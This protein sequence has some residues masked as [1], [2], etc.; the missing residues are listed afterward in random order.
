AS[1]AFDHLF[2]VGLESGTFPSRAPRS[3]VL[4]EWERERLVAAGLSID[5]P[6]AWDT[7]ERE[8]FR[9]LVAGAR[10]GL[11]LAWSQVDGAGRE[12]VRSAFVDEV[13]EAAA[14]DCEEIPL[15]RV[16]T[17]GMPLCAT[18][19]AA[20]HAHRVATIEQGRASGALSPWNGEIRDPS[21]RRWIAHEFGED[22][23][24]SPTQLEHYA[25]CAWAYFAERLLRIETREEPD[26]GIEPSVRGRI[27][28]RALERFYDF[29]SRERGGAPVLLREDEG[30]KAVRDLERELDA[31]I[32]E[33]ERDGTW[34]GA[35][36]LRTA[37]RD[38]LARIL[39]R[40]VEFELDWNRKLFGNRGNNPR[41]LRTGVESH[42]VRFDDVTLNADGVRVRFR[43]SIDRVE[44]GVDDRVDGAARFVAAVD[45]KTS[46][47]A[48]PGGGDKAAWDD[49]VVL[50]VPI[51]ARVLEELYPGESVSRIEYRSLKGKEVKHALQLY[52]VSKLPALEENDDDNERMMGAMTAIARHV[53]NARAGRFPAAP[54]PS[55]G[56]PSY[57]PAI[58]VCRVPGG[59]RTKEW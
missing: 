44:R 14:L 55:C 35:P 39:R 16:L 10:D 43:G 54:A 34:L 37:L 5:P 17:D 31:T 12:V 48:V 13:E 1:R 36:A 25:R 15:S 28:H 7:R 41:V 30:P 45:Y 9:V 2:V 3:P 53:T 40:Y 24:W 58:D 33:F 59:P 38:E 19:D 8:L 47:S 46:T 56:C 51:Y 27:L 21:L 26:D 52:Q 11:T 49:G 29:A 57:C 4:G 20:A 23:V 22:R 50:Q 6:D 32:G 18:E 42:E